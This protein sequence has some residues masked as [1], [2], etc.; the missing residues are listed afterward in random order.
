M[1]YCSAFVI[2]WICTLGSHGKYVNLERFKFRSPD[3]FDFGYLQEFIS[4]MNKLETL[5]VD[6]RIEH[7][8]APTK[9]LSSHHP[10]LRSLTLHMHF[11][12]ET[13]TSHSV[14]LSDEFFSNHSSIEELKIIDRSHGSTNVILPQE[15]MPALRALCLEYIPFSANLQFFQQLPRPIVHISLVGWFPSSKQQITSCALCLKQISATLRCCELSW[16]PSQLQK[17]PSFCQIVLKL[18]TRLIELGVVM[19]KPKSIHSTRRNELLD[20]SW[21]VSLCCHRCN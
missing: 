10:H 2:Q 3:T 19:Y 9:V 21:M 11:R 8:T 17:L 13:E 20:A 1:T 14:T 16:A 15:S 6:T 12:P 5:S 4:S 18:C 7:P